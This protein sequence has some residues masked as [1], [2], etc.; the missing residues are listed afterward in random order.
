[1]TEK[2]RTSN[3]QAAA[4]VGFRSS[5]STTFRKDYSSCT[6]QP[7]LYESPSTAMRQGDYD[8]CAKGSLSRI[9]YLLVLIGGPA[10]GIS[11]LGAIS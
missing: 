3:V 7:K 4:A 11:R 6:P 9:P 2:L 10:I 1:M 8:S 5:L